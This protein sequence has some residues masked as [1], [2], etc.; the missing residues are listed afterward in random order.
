M[1]NRGG[2]GGGG[3]GGGGERGPPRRRGGGRGRGGP[4]PLHEEQP[5][6]STGAASSSSLAGEFQR[7]LSIQEPAHPAAPPPSEPTPALPEQKLPPSSSKALRFP[8]RPGLG[9]LGMKC[10]VRANHFLVEVAANL[11]IFHY[12]AV[13]IP[14]CALAVSVTPEIAS[15]GVNRAIFKELLEAYAESHLGK[16]K[17]VYDGRKSIYTAGPLPFESKEFLVKLIDKDKTSSAR[18][19][20]EFRVTIKFAA[21]ADVH[22]L[23]QFLHGRQFDTPQ[24]TIQ[25]LDVVL[26]ETPSN[27]YITV[28]RS[29]FAPDMGVRTSI[30]D[31]LECWRGFYQSIRPTQMGLSLNIDMANTAFYEP[32]PVLDF[33]AQYLYLRDLSR[34]LSDSN[35]VKIKKVL[36]GV[37]SV[38]A[39]LLIVYGSVRFPTDDQGHRTSVIQYFMERYNVR[40]SSVALPC[41]QAGSES[42]PIYL[43]MELCNIIEGQRCSKKLNERQVTAIL[44]AACQRP[45]DRE[46]SIHQMAVRNNYKA[47]KNAKEFGVRVHDSLVSIDARV[48]P[49]PELKYHASGREPNCKPSVG[50]W[51]MINKKMV[52]GGKTF[53]PNPLLPPRSGNPNRIEMSLTEIHDQARAK[54]HQMGAKTMLQLLIII[55]PDRTG[56]Y[57]LGIVSQCCQPRNASRISKQYLENVALKINVKVGG[58]NT[59]LAD[60]LASRIPLVTDAPTIIFGADVT[61]PSPG[62]DSSPSIAAVVASMDWPEVTKYRGLVSAQPHRQE[63]IKDL[64]QVIEDPQRGA[65]SRGMIRDGVSEGQ[66][67][68]VLL[69]ELD[70]I[71]K[72]CA[73]LEEGYLPPVTFIVV[74]KR[75]HT[76]LFPLDS[77]NRNLTDKSGN[78][79]PGTV[80]DTK[81]C[82]PIEFDFYLCSHAGIQKMA[83]YA[84]FP[85]AYYAHLAAF[86]ARYYIESEASDSESTPTGGNV[87]QRTAEVRP[88]PQIKDN[89]KEVMFYC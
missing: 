79:L 33:I 67:G 49:P 75:H 42:K 3:G 18:R 37:K 55:L 26:R 51:N 59:V 48:L 20:R 89:V 15:R 17:P 36:R 6:P 78:I 19:E 86:R 1:S 81:I 22:N 64:F 69:Y 14:T 35:R 68:Q 8:P 84:R 82:H 54:L 83:L 62:E 50:Q 88:L 9:T 77:R 58:R 53:S 28:Q 44:K 46:K 47:D 45:G 31:G 7:T 25:A 23:L 16:K 4:S 41:L 65:V 52:D 29:F 70:A 11:A 80:V 32:I 87:R 2:R 71:R 39:S 56:S 5:L 63:L 60:A 57:E 27:R 61:H 43:P 72:A 10:T 24:E 12:D 40:L 13:N 34:P 21:R 73:S 30:G 76:R 38:D 66:F 85:P 74:Q